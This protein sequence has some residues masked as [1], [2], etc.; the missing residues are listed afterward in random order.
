MGGIFFVVYWIDM[1]T[2]AFSQEKRLGIC[3]VVLFTRQYADWM[4]GLV[5]VSLRSGIYMHEHTLFEMCVCVC[6]CTVRVCVRVEQQQK[7]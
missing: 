3:M 2:H 1:P 4:D 7:K 5:C 6:V